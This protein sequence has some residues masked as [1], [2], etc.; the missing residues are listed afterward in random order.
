MFC[1]TNF[2]TMKLFRKLLYASVMI[3]SVNYLFAQNLTGKQAPPLSGLVFVHP[4]KNN[5]PPFKNQVVVLEFWATWC[6]PCLANIPH[7]NQLQKLYR[8]SG[9]VFVSITDEPIHKTELFLKKRNMLGWVACDT[10]KEVCKRYAVSSLPRTLIIGKT[11]TVLFDGTP[12]GLTEKTLHDALHGGLVKEAMPMPSACHKTGSW[13]GGIDPVF[14]A[15]FNG[16]QARFP[17]QHTIRKSVFGSDRSANGYAYSETFSGMTL[18][19]KSISELTAS[20]ISLPS[21]KRVI[22]HSGISDTLLWDIVFSRNRL[23]TPDTMQEMILASLKETL[24]I[25]IT[26][27]ILLVNTITVNTGSSTAILNEQAIDFND[28]STK[29]Y[30]SLHEL[31]TRLETKGKE[32]YEITPG[33]EKLY[34]D[35]YPIFTNIHKMNTDELTVWLTS[36]GV[37]FGHKTL[38]VK[39]HIIQPGS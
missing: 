38:P 35:V 17:Y 1:S 27:T 16:T 2:I 26:D 25:T 14:T 34:I 29:T 4:E 22:N 19:A 6:M 24:H 18:L 10:A 13:G 39:H 9:V 31:L 30:F 36:Q 11:G 7:L 5:P 20:C 12:G 23:I 15:H 21:R 8:D 33:H 32:I 37:V 3:A 28:P